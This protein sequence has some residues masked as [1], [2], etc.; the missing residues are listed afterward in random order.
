MQETR[1]TAA[2]PTL[3]AK[4]ILRKLFLEDWLLKLSALVI[5]FALW[6]G[7]SY[8]NKKGTATMPAQL[9]FR[10]SDTSVL[11]NAGVQEV[12]IRVSGDDQKIDQLFGS[13]R[14]ITADLTDLEPGDRVIQLTPNNVTVDLPMG[15]KL[16]DIQPSR[17]A[18]R[19]EQVQV[20]DLPVKAETVGQP[21]SGFEIYNTTVTPARVTIRGPESYVATLDFVPTGAVDITGAKDDMTFRQVPVSLP[22][23]NAAVFNTVVDV[24]VRIGEKRVERTLALTTASGKR[25]TAV[26]YGPRSLMSNVKPADLKVDISKLDTGEET[27][28]LTLPDS[29]QG[30]VEIRTLKIGS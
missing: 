9:K 27:P 19:L 14:R 3:F 2:R 4:H 26:L 7:V 17:I 11:T 10:V 12:S 28:H 29:L 8:S 24:A 16:E 18:V 21:A 20:K 6:F 5:T 23:T 30:S 13:D 1:S 15:V 22:N 25:V